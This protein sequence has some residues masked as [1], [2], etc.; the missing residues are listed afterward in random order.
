[1][2]IKIV[3]S[4]YDFYVIRDSSSNQKEENR[5]SVFVD[6]LTLSTA[7]CQRMLEHDILLESKE[8]GKLQVY[9]IVRRDRMYFWF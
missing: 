6:I 3:L 5:T 8:S 2:L 1:M 4:K 7:V 9:Q